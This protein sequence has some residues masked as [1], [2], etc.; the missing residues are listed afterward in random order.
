MAEMSKKKKILATSIAV[1]AA[2]I[3]LIVAVSYWSD[4]EALISGDKKG[5]TDD[6]QNQT[7]SDNKP[8]VAEL[9]A[10]PDRTEVLMPV[11]LDG[12]ASYDPDNESA[13]NKGIAFYV[14]DFGDKSEA[15]TLNSGNTTHTYSDPGEY[16]ITLTVIDSDGGR[17]TASV[18]VTIVRETLTFGTPT[19]I[20]IGEPIIIGVV[21]NS[22]E[23]NWTVYEDFTYVEITVSVSGMDFMGLESNHVEIILYDPYEDVLANE[24]LTVIGSKV[25]SWE[26]GPGDLEITGQYYLFIQ[27][28]KGAAFVSVE[29][30]VT[31]L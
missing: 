24:T 23:V 11:F 14:F 3:L 2:V 31:Y 6:N 4:I 20:L 9:F 13:P 16:L 29:G 30:M 28:T 26:F 21:G 5:K 12:N 22:T 8:P 27:C 25:V 10:D 17:D 19:T 7:S 18:V 1:V 15:E